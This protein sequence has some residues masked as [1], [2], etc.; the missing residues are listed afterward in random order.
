M[1]YV[2]NTWDAQAPMPVFRWRCKR[3]VAVTHLAETPA[4]IETTFDGSYPVMT[5]S[6][7]LKMT[8]EIVDLPI[9]NGDFP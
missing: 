2:W 3:E 5:N 8:I 1:F 9:E 7:L 4:M 6:L